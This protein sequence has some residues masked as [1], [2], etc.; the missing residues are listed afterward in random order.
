[1]NPVLQDNTMPADFYDVLEVSR[2]A[3]ADEI[4]KSYRKLSRENHPDVKPDDSS[5]AGKFQEVQDAYTVLND[6]D[7]RRKYDQYGHRAFQGGGGGAG[8]AGGPVDL[9]D[10]F[11]GGIDLGSLFGG[12]MGGQR[13]P[14]KGQDATTSIQISFNTAAEGGSY[15]LAL[16]VAGSSQRIT[17]RIPAGI[18][19]GKTIRLADQGHPGHGGGP[20]GDLLVSV[21]VSP[22]PYFSR[23]GVSLF[24]DVPLSITEATLGAKVDV[25]TLSEGMLTISIPPGAASGMKLRL[26]EKGIL[27]QKTNQRGD[28]F[29]V[30]KIVSPKNLDDESR[31][32]VEELA[33]LIDENPR[34]D[35]W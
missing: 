8:G 26:R 15:D 18:D 20:N 11:G 23:D 12:G 7:K 22:H 25:P 21:N 17:I 2:K 1:V 16:N 13:R 27:N 5:A 30:L 24:V 3:S 28:L 10:L 35:I 19:H 31:A 32:L 29:A 34:K 33:E 9:G 4:R 14:Q 6:P